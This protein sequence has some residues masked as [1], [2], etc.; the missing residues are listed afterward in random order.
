MLVMSLV[1]VFGGMIFA[2]KTMVVTGDSLVRA[3]IAAGRIQFQ[4]TCFSLGILIALF[5]NMALGYAVLTAITDKTS[6]E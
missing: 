5:G 1:I 6:K 4:N 2:S 3:E